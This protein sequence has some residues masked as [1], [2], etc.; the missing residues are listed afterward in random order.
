MR[1]S[2]RSDLSCSNICHNRQ[3]GLS[4]V[5]RSTFSSKMNCDL[6]GA[7][8]KS[9]LRVVGG[10][11]GA[12]AGFVAIASP[13][14]YYLNEAMERESAHQYNGRPDFW[15]GLGGWAVILFVTI[16]LGFV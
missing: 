13:I 11:V 10:I 16:F 6:R 15:A 14:N 3:T 5:A 9:F 2:L 7:F 1:G 4:P 8:M 12:I